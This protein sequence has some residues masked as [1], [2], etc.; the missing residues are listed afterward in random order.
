MEVDWVTKVRGGKEGWYLCNTIK[1]Q[2]GEDVN[3]YRGVL[4]KEPGVGLC[5]KSDDL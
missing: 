3:N 5:I 1:G 4:L 2:T